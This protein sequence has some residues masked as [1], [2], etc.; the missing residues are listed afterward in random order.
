[1]SS[2]CST[3]SGVGC[4]SATMTD[5]PSVLHHVRSALMMSNVAALSRPVEISSHRNRLWPPTSTSPTVTRLRS[6][7]LTPRSSALP[8]TVSAQFSRPSIC[9]NSSVRS[10]AMSRISSGWSSGRPFTHISANL[11][12]SRTVN[13]GMWLSVW[14]TRPTSLMR[15]MS[16]PFRPE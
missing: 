11:N 4:S 7:P 1:M 16:A 5:P 15:S 13:V 14:S 6:P 12:V 8:T 9:R 10:A 3:T 2:N